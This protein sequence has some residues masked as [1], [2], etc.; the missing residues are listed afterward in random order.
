M[1]KK[2]LKIRLSFLHDP[3]TWQTDRQ[4]YRHRMTAKAVLDAS[5]AWQK[6]Y[7]CI[8]QCSRTSELEPESERMKRIWRFVWREARQSCGIPPG[9]WHQAAP[10]FLLE[11]SPEITSSHS[12]RQA[13]TGTTHSKT[14]MGGKNYMQTHKHKQMHGA[15]L[16]Q[17]VNAQTDCGIKQKERKENLYLC[18][19]NIVTLKSGLEV[20]QGHWN[21]C[22]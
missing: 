2:S 5:I 13:D 12:R 17:R 22:H 19:S 15:L 9:Q 1:V 8:A 6:P 18:I 3:R 4:T 7:N 14:E 20:T 16:D 10:P 21:W 11:T